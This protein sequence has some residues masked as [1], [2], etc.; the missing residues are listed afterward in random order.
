M[1]NELDDF[2]V[3]ASYDEWADEYDEE[4]A[5]FEA[6]AQEIAED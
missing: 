3:N 2:V 6:F 4:M 1:R 5:L